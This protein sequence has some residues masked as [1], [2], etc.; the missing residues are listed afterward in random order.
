MTTKPICPNCESDDVM[1]DSVSAWSEE[2]QQFETIN[3]IDAG[4]FCRDCG[5]DIEIKP[6]WVIT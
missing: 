4:H 3:V 2:N 5:S 6:K 1:F